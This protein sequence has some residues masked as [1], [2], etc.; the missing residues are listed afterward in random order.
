MNGYSPVFPKYPNPYAY[1]IPF[2]K[3]PTSKPKPF[4]S[5]PVYF[6]HLY[7]LTSLTHPPTHSQENKSIS[8]GPRKNS[9]GSSQIN[10]KS[11]TTDSRPFFLEPPQP[12][13]QR[14]PAFL[15]IIIIMTDKDKDK[16]DRVLPIPDTH[17][18]AGLESNKKNHDDRGPPCK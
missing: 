13:N 11:K 16:N 9:V 6:T 1:L 3:N 15:P 17:Q 12:I 10:I 7:P 2:K 8:Q 18:R 4:S 14:R 5:Y